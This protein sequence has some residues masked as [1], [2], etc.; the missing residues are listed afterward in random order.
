MAEYESVITKINE[1]TKTITTE[2]VKKG[3]C[4]ENCLSI[5]KRINKGQHYVALRLWREK[6]ELHKK[7]TI[8]MVDDVI[9][10]L[11][12][13]VPNEFD[14]DKIHTKIL[15]H[16][17]KRKRKGK[18][19][20]NKYGMEWFIRKFNH[21]DKIQLLLDAIIDDIKHRMFPRG[22]EAAVEELEK[23]IEDEDFKPIK[24]IKLEIEEMA[25]L[26]LHLPNK[27]LGK[28]IRE[29]VL[30]NAEHFADK[31]K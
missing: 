1:E 16:N 23:K 17:E 26:N 7:L 8:R 10:A 13:I 11:Q 27:E 25:K 24:I 15:E 9:D 4:C 20:Y 18:K 29:A 30:T 31:E 6:R 3:K 28:L 5:E 2:R 22:R 12:E 21:K 19:Y 14:D